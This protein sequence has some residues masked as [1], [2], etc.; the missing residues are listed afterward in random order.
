MSEIRKDPYGEYL[1]ETMYANCWDFYEELTKALEDGY[2]RHDGQSSIPP[3]S[4]LVPIGTADEVTYHSKP[5]WSFRI[6]IRW[7][8]YAS[9]FNNPDREYIQCYTTDL[10]KP[11]LRTPSQHGATSPV[12]ANCVALFHDGKYHIVYGEYFDRAKGEWKWKD[13]SVESTLNN[14]YYERYL[15]VKRK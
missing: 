7:N 4:C 12:I 10:P 1:R 3:S 11:R 8:W 5:E 9:E 15:K 6:A 14:M 13:T 2:E